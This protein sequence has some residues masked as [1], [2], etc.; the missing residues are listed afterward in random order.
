MSTTSPVVSGTYLAD[1][2]HSSFGFSVQYQGVSVYR[3]TF[4]E[5]E[6]KLTDG[7]LEGV[8]QVE[9]VSIRNPAQF[10]AHVMSPEF[11]DAEKH[12]E[13]RFSSSEL[14]LGDDG[15]AT[16]AGDLTIK[17]ITRPVQAT[18][19]F[20]PPA[21]DAF[22]NVRAH[23]RLEAVVDRT[24]YDIHWNMALPTGGQALGNDVTLTIE[25]SLIEEA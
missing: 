11:F 17:G 22:N 10:R 21:T 15:T 6:A 7:R 25:L 14:D 12:A 9:S 18:G 8:A 20:T 13:I 3:G 4:E 5:V 1:P 23:L 24:E 2:V 16:V 19:S